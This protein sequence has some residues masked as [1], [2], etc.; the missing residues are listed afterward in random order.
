MP[1]YLSERAHE[2]IRSTAHGYTFP[3]GYPLAAWVADNEPICPECV[4]SNLRLI[5]L[6]THDHEVN[7]PGFD[8]QWAVVGCEV[9][10]E[11][12]HLVCSH[13]CD[14]IPS[15]YGEAPEEQVRMQAIALPLPEDDQP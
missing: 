3:G 11:D 8:P 14:W 9:N 13:C 1:K 10:W 12:A 15:A 6:A 7:P 4:R 2:A 5:V